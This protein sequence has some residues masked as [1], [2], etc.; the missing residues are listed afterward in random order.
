MN[1]PLRALRKANDTRFAVAAVKRRIAALPHEQAVAEVRHLLSD[2]SG[3]EGSI[4]ADR[5]LLAI[6]GCG[7]TRV[8]LVL[9]R[10]GIVGASRQVR[11]MTRSQREALAAWLTAP[12]WQ[13]R[14]P[15]PAEPRLDNNRVRT[16]A[17][18]LRARRPD[19]TDPEDVARIVLA[20]DRPGVR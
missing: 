6:P 20:V 2:P 4:H 1:Q 12:M 13:L 3:P 9:R 18:A 10:A 8:R 19:V 5:L 14:R 17:T 7:P 16:A 11:H 15:G